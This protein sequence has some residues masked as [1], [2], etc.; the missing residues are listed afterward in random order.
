MEE[1]LMKGHICHI[2]IPADNLG[3]LQ[4]FY[5]GI[6]EWDFEKVPG[7]FEYYGIRQGDDKPTA[8]M[9]VRQFPD[10]KTIFYVCVESVEAALTRVKE[11]GAT[12]IM[13]RTAVKGM[14]WYAVVLDPQ[15]NPFGLWQEDE[16]AP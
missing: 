16:S 6:F 14:G 7:D 13:P 4:K 5:S 10:Q 9:M 12:V 8:G 1:L 11:E 15:K 3:V 2:E